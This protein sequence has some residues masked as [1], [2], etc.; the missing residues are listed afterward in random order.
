MN[1]KHIANVN[2]LNERNETLQ[3]DLLRL[4][5]AVFEPSGVVNH[6]T[7]E[8]SAFRK[9]MVVGGGIKGHGVQFNDPSEIRSFLAPLEGSVAVFHDAVSLLHCIGSVTATHHETMTEMKAQRD[10]HVSSDLEA[11][12]VTSFRTILPSAL[13]GSASDAGTEPHVFLL[14]ELKSHKD[15]HHDDGVSGVSQ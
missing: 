8:V 6:L 13:F 4:R 12:V 1:R 14:S 3:N 7:E 5:Q 15:W 9:T 11:R 2:H 10:V